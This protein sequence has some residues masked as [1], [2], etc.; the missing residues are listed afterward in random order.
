VQFNLSPGERLEGCLEAS[1]GTI[2]W[3]K[4]VGAYLGSDGKSK[5]YI[6]RLVEYLRFRAGLCRMIFLEMEWGKTKVRYLLS[7][8]C[9][10]SCDFNVCCY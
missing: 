10:R 4:P 6:V 3:M 1:T 2:E 8:G 7:H 5:N 9:W